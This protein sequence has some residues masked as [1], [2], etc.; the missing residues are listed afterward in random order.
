MAEGELAPPIAA[1][2]A[3]PRQRPAP[4]PGERR[5]RAVPQPRAGPSRLGPRSEPPPSREE[6]G[7]ARSAQA[8]WRRPAGGRAP[9]GGLSIHSLIRDAGPPPPSRARPLERRP[10][11]FWSRAPPASTVVSEPR[12]PFLFLCVWVLPEGGGG[13]E[14]AGPFFVRFLGEKLDA[15][16]PGPV[17][18]PATSDASHSQILL[19]PSPPMSSVPSPCLPEPSLDPFCRKPVGSGSP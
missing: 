3:R 7:A 1:R 6:A 2:Q 13:G 5:P 12:V 4:R 17:P 16:D 9:A 14:D 15:S 8:T 10:R 18:R 11:L 19:C